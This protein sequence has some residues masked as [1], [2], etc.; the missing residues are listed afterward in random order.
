MG[1]KA[2]MGVPNTV[3]PLMKAFMMKFVTFDGKRQENTFE[4]LKKKATGNETTEDG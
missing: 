4:D 2:L 3:L 1:G